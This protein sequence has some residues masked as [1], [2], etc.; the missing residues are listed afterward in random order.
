MIFLRL[1]VAL[2]HAGQHRMGRGMVYLGNSNTLLNP[3]QPR[4]SGYTCSASRA[5]STSTVILPSFLN[6]LIF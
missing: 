2:E 4:S 1:S 5:S 6:I 3:M